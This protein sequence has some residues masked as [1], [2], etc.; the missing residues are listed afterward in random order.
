MNLRL[1]ESQI[2]N[3]QSFESRLSAENDSLRSDLAR[4]GALV[5]SVQRIEASLSAKN[6]EDAT[7]LEEN[8]KLTTVTL[9]EEHRKHANESEELRGQISDTELR[10]KE[11]E[12]K[13]SEALADMVKAKED[14]LQARS[15]FTAVSERCL[16]LEN[17]LS[18]ANNRLNEA[19]LEATERDQVASIAT[20]FE[21]AKV[22]LAKAKERIKDLQ[23]ISKAN[24][25][26][27]GDLTVAQEEYRKSKESELDNLKRDLASAQQLAQMKKEMLDELSKEL[28]S[29]RSD[30][31]KVVSDLKSKVVRLESCLQSSEDLAEAGKM[32][33]ES[34]TKEIKSYRDEATT[35]QVSVARYCF[36]LDALLFTFFPLI[37]VRYIYLTK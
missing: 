24:E 18:E 9:K 30:Q 22:D 28:T 21:K 27:V 5:D 34:L 3:A 11:A 14:K 6:A 19:G 23:G 37:C 13:S 1:A 2:K 20:K 31:E 25:K 33:C 29:H 17:V 8:L 12:K 7:R 16:S 35:A 32:R 36:W 26:E 15:D 10:L 4:Q